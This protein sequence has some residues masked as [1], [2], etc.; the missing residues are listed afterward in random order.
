MISKDIAEKKLFLL[1]AYALIYRAYFAFSKNPR[2]NSQGL[3]TSAIFGFT[4]TLI[5]ILQK[6][7]PTH[8]AV[9]F[10]PPSPPNRALDYTEYKANRE[11][12]PEDIK[13][14]VPFIKRICEG[15]RIPILMKDG[16]EA[17]DV[18]GTLAKMAE[19][20]GF[21]TYMMTPDKD[22]AQLVSENIFMYKPGRMGNPPQIWGV[23]EV[24]EKFEVERV[25]QVIDILGMWGDSVDNIPGIPGIGEKTAKKFI[26]AYGSMEGLYEHVDDLKGKQ[27]INVETNK[28]QAFMSKMLATIITDV[29]VP[30]EPQKLIL[31]DPDKDALKEV[32]TE[33]EFRRMAERYLGEEIST[34]GATVA[35]GGQPSLF[36]QPIEEKQQEEPDTAEEP[37]A[38]TIE[39]T[40]HT[41]HFINDEKAIAQLI[42][43]LAAQK[44]FCFDTE[45]T[46]VESTEA[47]LVGLSFSWKTGEGYYVPVSA[48]KE[49]AQALV[50]QFKPLLEDENI[51]KIGQNLKY[52]ITVL[53]K[54]DVHVSGKMFDTMIAHYLLHPDMNRRNMDVL[55]ETYLNYKPVSITEL[56]GKKGKNQKSMRDLAPEEVSDYA[57]EDADIT[58]QLKEHFA[59]ELEASNAKKLFDEVE[60]PLV[61]VLSDME[62]EGINLDVDA[63]KT[64]SKELAEE[65]QNIEKSIYEQAGEEFNIGSPKQV[66]EI[67]FDKLKVTDKAK[68]TKSGQYATNEEVLQKLQGKHPII[69]LILDYRE[70]VKL[71]NT[72]VDP[73]PNMINPLTGRIHTSYNQVI[74]ATGRLSSDNP[75]LQNIPVRTEKGRRIREAFVPRNEEYTLL[76]AD[77]SQI[78]LRIIAALSGDEGML[79]AFH[80][81]TDIHATTASKVYGVAL[82]EVTR[83]MRSNAK[84]VNFGIIY[85][86]S[87][88]GLSQRINISRREAKEIIDNYFEQFP[89]IKSYMDE[90]IQRAR[91]NGYVETILGR[92]RYLRDINSANAVVRGYAE[93]NAINA[94]IQGSAADIIKVAMINVDKRFK[95]EGF[96]SKMLLQVHDELVFDAH[97]DEVETITPIIKELM[98]GAIPM[99][100]PMEVEANTG[101]NWLEAH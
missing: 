37:T 69:D 50:N 44:S 81:G 43:D 95:K 30:F 36:D 101:S 60:M 52:D 64:Y 35:N 79:E 10:D 62:Q 46:S 8:I 27:K 33:L 59:P 48:D 68:K 21:V 98:S 90:S 96:R 88:F 40:E 67:L 31:E 6:E 19:K 82:D 58:L 100:V 7:K 5:D 73:L 56:I 9:V 70:V 23:E 45:T 18:I 32:F 28:E 2:I 47:E 3:N 80:S 20:E 26:K 87:A 84:T 97:K 77:Y 38:Q 51:E 34:A 91:E 63:L 71:K 11:E 4:N 65:V 99:D 14:S 29:E 41:Y 76:A 89:K 42:K 12:T 55:A 94:P 22:Y 24:Q 39:N 92:R 25:E 75:N 93:R 16:Y 54:Y 49:E 72:Y 17:D 53:K 66:G 74:A 78:E 86:I 1:D 83:E 61:P 15:F 13:L 85:G 57:C